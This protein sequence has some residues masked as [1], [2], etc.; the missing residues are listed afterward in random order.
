MITLLQNV[1]NCWAGGGDGDGSV[2][3]CGDSD[4]GDGGVGGRGGKHHHQ[5]R[6][7]SP[8]PPPTPL[9]LTFCSK[10][11]TISIF[12]EKILYFVLAISRSN[13]TQFLKI[14]TVLKIPLSW[15]L[16][17]I[18]TSTSNNTTPT[19]TTTNTAI[20]TTNPTVAYILQQS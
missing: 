17:T 6:H 20:T 10:V 2:G 14:L 8:S 12:L 19:S 9:L 7:H 15:L 3:G 5:H 11:I 1:S 13:F 4:C 16:N 18:T